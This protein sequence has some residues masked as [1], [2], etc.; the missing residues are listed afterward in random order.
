MGSG[1][2]MGQ[3]T[4]TI[5]RIDAQTLQA[6]HTNGVINDAKD[7]STGAS[8]ATTNRPYLVTTGDGMI[9]HPDDLNWG[10]REVFF[11]DSKNV[12]IQITGVDSNNKVKIWQCVGTDID[13]VFTIG[14]WETIQPP[15]IETG[16]DTNEGLTKLYSETGA[17]TDGTLTQ[18]AISELF[19]KNISI[20]DIDKYL[21]IFQSTKPDEDCEARFWIDTTD[22]T[23]RISIPEIRDEVVNSIDTWSSKKIQSELDN[24]KIS[25][26]GSVTEEIIVAAD[27]VENET[28]VLRPIPSMNYVIFSGTNVSE[29]IEDN[30]FHTV[31]LDNTVKTTGTISDYV[32]LSDGTVL[33]TPG[34]YFISGKI[35]VT[36]CTTETIALGRW[37][38]STDGSTFR[39]TAETENAEAYVYMP[40]GIVQA[41]LILTGTVLNVSTDT[42]LRIQISQRS[43]EPI[44]ISP[45]ACRLQITKLK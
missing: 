14:A 36:S 43:S 5:R 42:Y 6:A 39:V 15:V 34:V 22:A 27:S 12:I 44:I 17:N 31:L 20:V 24:L 40:S 38:T 10:I 11:Y 8:N 18:K 25:S 28:L 1:I 32:N 3:E 9:N 37:T 29:T 7:I 30:N 33:L 41:K 35:Q 21:A 13:G 4:R 2:L 16:D 23:T 26:G 45:Q 19:D